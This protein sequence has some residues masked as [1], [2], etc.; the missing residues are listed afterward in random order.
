MLR[1]TLA[2]MRQS[3]G[4]LLGVLALPV[5]PGGAHALELR[6]SPPDSVYLVDIHR[7]GVVFDLLVQNIAVVNDGPG[8]ASVDSFRCDALR[9]GVVVASET[10]NKELLERAWALQKRYFDR[11]GVRTS[12]ES[13]FEFHRLLGDSIG[14]ATGVTLPPKT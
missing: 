1:P 13:T 5:L 2:R 10:W 6:V 3:L 12:E 9:Q 4:L 8:S 14:F 7:T 11:P